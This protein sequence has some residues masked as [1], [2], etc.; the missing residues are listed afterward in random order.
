MPIFKLSAPKTICLL[1]GY[2]LPRNASN[3]T[4]SQTIFEK[5]SREKLLDPCLYMDRKGNGRGRDSRLPTSKGMGGEGKGQG[6]AE[7]DG[8]E[9][10]GGGKGQCKD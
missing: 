2:I 3:F 7:R 9:K 1:G 5:F 6:R 10:A 4:C 8:M